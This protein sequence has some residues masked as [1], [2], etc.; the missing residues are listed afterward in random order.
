[1]EECSHDVLVRGLCVSCGADLS[2][3]GHDEHHSPTAG[4]GLARLGDSGL[5]HLVPGALMRNKAKFADDDARRVELARKLYLIL[6]LDETLIHAA[7]GQP[8]A[9]A[10]PRRA[11]PGIDDQAPDGRTV[12]MIATTTGQTVLLRPHLL[13][14]LRR[15]SALFQISLYTMGGQDYARAVLAAIDPTNLYFRGGL[16]AWD[17]G[18]TRSKKE[19]SRVPCRRDMVL[20]VDDTA[21][22][23][24][25]DWRSLCLIPRWMGEPTDDALLHIG[26]HLAAVHAATY[27]PEARAPSGALPDV[28][29][30]LARTRPTF[31]SGC[32]FAFSGLFPRGVPLLEQVLCQLICACGGECDDELSER[33][34]HLIF[35]RPRT[36]KIQ[37]AALMRRAHGAR[38]SILWEGWLLACLALWRLLPEKHMALD[39]DEATGRAPRAPGVRERAA[40]PRAA[41][42][43]G[44]RIGKRLRDVHVDGEASGAPEAARAVGTH[45]GQPGPGDIGDA[46]ARD[47]APPRGSGVGTIEM[48][49]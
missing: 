35:R 23:W 49:A 48:S 47:G 39:V 30:L 31:F 3:E 9:H 32:V 44:A 4:S 43:G 38:P 21:D 36:D 5:A 1:M 40:E 20:V 8:P 37:R 12:E 25:Q 22:V 16:C 18:L 28:R 19:L 7:R 13:A 2:A 41:E 14:F 27:A 15:M 46:G 24:A 10:V 11:T 29:E 34:T 26:D 17:D 42:E 33:T 45:G 6:D